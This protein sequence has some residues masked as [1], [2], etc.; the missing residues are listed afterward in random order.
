M[1]S[2]LLHGSLYMRMHLQVSDFVTYCLHP[3]GAL[4]TWLAWLNCR[5]GESPTGRRGDSHS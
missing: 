2:S 3:L 4:L 5:A 1:F